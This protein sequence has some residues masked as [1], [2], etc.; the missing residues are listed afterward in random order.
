MSLVDIGCGWG[1]PADP[2]QRNTVKGTGITLSEEQYRNFPENQEEGLEDLLT[3]KLLDY[4]ELPETGLTSTGR[5]AGMVEHVGRGNCQLSQLR[6]QRI[7]ARG[8]FL[9]HFISGLKEYPG[10]PG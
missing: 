4:R 1:L 8:L 9:L 5:S 6:E 10:D 7:K 3:V 2:R